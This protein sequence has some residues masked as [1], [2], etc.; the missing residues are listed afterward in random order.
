MAMGF[1][2]GANLL[3]GYEISNPERVCEIILQKL[4]GTTRKLEIVFEAKIDTRN[5]YFD[6][7]APFGRAKR[8]TKKPIV[9]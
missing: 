3:A 7:H 8:D 9:I 6:Y 5:R 4:T 2:Y 1:C